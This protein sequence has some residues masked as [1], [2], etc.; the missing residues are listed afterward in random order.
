MRPAH[1]RLWSH[2]IFTFYSLM[3]ENTLAG[4]RFDSTPFKHGDS[5]SPVK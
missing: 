5:L 2:V 3:L 1:E 4:R